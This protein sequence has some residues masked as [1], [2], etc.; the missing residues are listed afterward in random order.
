MSAIGLV[1]M[2]I[3]TD[4]RGLLAFCNTVLVGIIKIEAKPIHRGDNWSHT[5]WRKADQ[6][7]ATINQDV[8]DEH[9][10]HSAISQRFKITPKEWSIKSLISI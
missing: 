9:A 4:D 7:D 2:G 1:K 3:E 8:L 6:R 5:G 10:K